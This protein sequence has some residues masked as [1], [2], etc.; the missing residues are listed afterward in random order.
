MA[1]YADNYTARYVI[2]YTCGGMSHKQM[3]RYG[4]ATDFGAIEASVDGI[5][6]C[7]VG[8]AL[9]LA[10]DLSFSGATFYPMGSDVGIP[11]TLPTDLATITV[12]GTPDLAAGPVY[13]SIPWS[14]TAGGKQ[15]MF[16]YGSYL[17][18][19]GIVGKDYRV[20]FGETLSADSTITVFNNYCPQITGNDR[21]PGRQAKR[22][23]NYGIN[24]ALVRKRRRG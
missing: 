9:L 10:S 8:V 7:W 20:Q 19:G 21:M 2:E 6:D 11:A 5:K 3:W 23:M 13:L 1:D 12:S 24:P 17:T 16:F 14:T 4:S 15:T 18:P 22:Y